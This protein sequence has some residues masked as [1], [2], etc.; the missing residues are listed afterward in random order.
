MRRNLPLKLII[1]QLSGSI[2][3]KENELL[4]SWLQD[5]AN[6][7]IYSEIEILWHNVQAKTANYTPDKSKYW[8]VLSLHIE[9][10]KAQSNQNSKKVFILKI[11]QTVAVACVLFVMFLGAEY[12]FYEIGN[13]KRTQ[14]I[15]PQVVSTYSSKG[16][17]SQVTLPDG[18]KVW[19]HSHT[20]LSYF[21]DN[22]N[23]IRSVKL[24]GEA[25]FIVT[26][27]HQIP[28]IVSSNGVDVKVYGTKFN[29][30][31]QPDA[32]SVNVVLMEGSVAMKADKNEI[33][34]NS[35]Q[36]GT[37][38]KLNKNINIEVTDVDLICAWA[39]D[40]ISFEQKSL[41]YVCRYLSS[42]YDI[43]IVIDSDIKDSYAYTMTIQDESLD[44]VMKILS[45]T[46]SFNYH[47]GENN[48]LFI[49]Q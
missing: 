23:N 40:K 17:K 47:Y 24:D 34:L 4:G 19:L 15:N 37:Y 12:L 20:M 21:F 29:V 28:F 36:Q 1:G 35:G 22:K 16:G 45:H 31:S 2:T 38:N 14:I 3:E 6:R 46:G 27:N 11:Y 49:T 48:T 10:D 8:K 5:D 25:F 13:I 9:K 41:G 26:S 32:N 43:E 39:K 33:F 18:S 44:E 42:W 7:K 30:D